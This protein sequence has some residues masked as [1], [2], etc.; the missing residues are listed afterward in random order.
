MTTSAGARRHLVRLVDTSRPDPDGEGGYT[1]D[2]VP[3]HPSE[4]MAAIV[5]ATARELARVMAGTVIASASHLVTMPFHPG[6]TTQTR[7]LFGA[8]RFAVLGV[9]NPEERN[10]ETVA[11]CQEVQP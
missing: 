5:P 10:I 6:V 8:R 4:V 11:A 9:A 1:E 3:L 2:G 7:V